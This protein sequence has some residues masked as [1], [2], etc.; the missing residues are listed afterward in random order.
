M[1]KIIKRGACGIALAI[2]PVAAAAGAKV[3]D[4]AVNLALYATPATSFVSDHETVDAINDGFEPRGVGDHSHGAYGNWPR[5][6]GV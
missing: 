3:K 1:N 4:D 5:M 6:E 2:I